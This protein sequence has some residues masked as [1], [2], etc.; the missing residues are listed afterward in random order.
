MRS[1][2]LRFVLLVALL[3][4]AVIT[5]SQNSGLNPGAIYTIKSKTGTKVLDVINSSMDD[6]ANVGCGTFTGSDAQKWILI[7]AGN[8]IYKIQNA[9]SSKFLNL[10]GM[11]ADSLNICQFSDTGRDD[12]RWNIIK[13]GQG[14]YFIKPVSD[15]G[16]SLCFSG[17]SVGG[18]EIGLARSAPAD[19]QKWLLQKVSPNNESASAIADKIFAAWYNG[20][21]MGSV[22][23]FFWDNAEMM[24]IVLDAYEI[25]GDQ[26]YRDMFET[27]YNNFIEKNG[28][29]W[30]HNKYNDDIAWA[31]LFSIRGYLLTGNT[32]YRDKAKEQFD[33]MWARA[34]TNSYGG[35]LL[36]YH[37]KTT[38][39]ACINGPSMVACCYLARAT[40]DSS[41]YDKAVSLYT[42]SKLYLFDPKTGKVNDNVDIDKK[43]GKLKISSWSSTYN[44]GTYLGAATMLYKY[45]KE[46]TYL[47]EAQRIAEYIRDK[48]YGSEVMNNEYNGNDLPGFK[49]IFARYAR[50]YTTE[51]NKTDLVDWLKLNA[52]VA[53]NNRNSKGLIHTKWASRTGESKPES[54]FGCS[55]AVS[56]LINSLPL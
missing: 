46:T 1:F 24:E 15:R 25:T 13:S 12:V 44:Q 6:G 4:N 28:S 29:D 43:T 50:M 31:V 56:L 3:I 8:G 11:N 33:K 21:D 53:Y 49:G 26:K 32:A 18:K 17:D 52:R 38:K 30:L 20:Y 41:Y 22:K 7:Q 9:A 10:S 19:N 39:N 16:T 55:A 51:L 5:H 37:T 14:Y 42:W 34:F 48:M 23:G 54:A 47:D 27:M 35:G 40:G 36:W 45:T 2:F